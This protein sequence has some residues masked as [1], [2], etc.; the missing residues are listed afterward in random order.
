MVKN[1]NNI[2]KTNIHLSF[3]L[4]GHKK[5][6]STYDVGNPGPVWRQAQ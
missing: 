3:E 1:F 5:K 6:T 4:I 2:S